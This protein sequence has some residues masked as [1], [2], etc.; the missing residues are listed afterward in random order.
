MNEHPNLDGAFFE[1]YAKDPR[2]WLLQGGQHKEAADI[3]WQAYQKGIP[4]DEN[5]SLWQLLS[6]H[7]GE[8][9]THMLGMA[10]ENTIKGIIIAC[11]PA[12]VNKGKFDKRFTT[13]NINDL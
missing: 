11:E 4:G 10:I 12:I 6:N 8:I 3:L 7:R 5:A 2:F 9:A 1:I 13:H